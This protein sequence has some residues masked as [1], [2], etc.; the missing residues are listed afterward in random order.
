MPVHVAVPVTVVM[1][2]ELGATVLHEGETVKVVGVIV[3]LAPTAVVG[4][5]MPT[6]SFAV[7]HTL[8]LFR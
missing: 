8:E 3:E 5:M 7:Y 4:F 6:V 1:F 2:D